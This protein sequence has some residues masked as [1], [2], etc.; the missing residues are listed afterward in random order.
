MKQLRSNSALLTDALGLPP[1]H[2]PR[3]KTG[4]LNGNTWRR[5]IIHR[6][7]RFGRPTS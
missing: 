5:P 7:I 2:A 1:R 4:T 3:G 6:Y